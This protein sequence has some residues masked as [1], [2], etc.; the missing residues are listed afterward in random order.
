V[1]EQTLQ[2]RA[3]RLAETHVLGG[4]SWTFPA[5]ARHGLG[6][7]LALYRVIHH[8]YWLRVAR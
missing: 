2:A 7:R 8:E 5:A 6:V 4:P 3:E 1:T